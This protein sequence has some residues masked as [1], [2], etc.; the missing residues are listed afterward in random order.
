MTRAT[1]YDWLAAGLDILA[2]QGAPALTIERLT[3]MLGLTK[4]S[5]YHHFE[6]LPGFKAALLRFIESKSA[7]LADGEGMICSPTEQIQSIFN[8]V[9][10][11]PTELEIAFRAWALQDE[12]VR[13]VQERVDRSRLAQ[14]KELC[15]QLVADEER[16]QVMGHLAHTLL[17]G[18]TQVQPPLPPALRRRLFDEFFRLYHLTE[19]HAQD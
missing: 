9:A 6:G 17:I 4:G 8:T 19:A 1:K 12:D 18:T 13:K 15:Q 7:S 11:S 10:M 5:F 14:M 16:A 3:A 2:E